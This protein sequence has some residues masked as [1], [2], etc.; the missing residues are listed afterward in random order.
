MKKFALGIG[1][2]IVVGIVIGSLVNRCD[3][4]TVTNEN[5]ID[6][7]VKLAQLKQKID[8]TTMKT[9]FNKI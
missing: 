3:P 8:T 5:E 7:A 6:F 2:L 4:T 1:L 9:Y